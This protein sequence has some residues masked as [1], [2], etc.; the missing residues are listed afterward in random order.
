MDNGKQLSVK[1]D[2]LQAIYLSRLA[3][4]SGRSQGQVIQRLIVH[5][6]SSPEALKA[7]GVW[8]WQT[9]QPKDINL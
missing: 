6:V 4:E 1:L 3:R 7:L 2:N 8:N 9:N 5:A